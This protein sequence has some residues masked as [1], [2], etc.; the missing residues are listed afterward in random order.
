[1]NDRAEAG[2]AGERLAASFL[3]RAGHRIITRNYRTPRGEIDLITEDGDDLVFVEVRLRRSS[4]YGG[5][6][7][8]VT[9]GK[10]RRLIRAAAR[11]L[12]EGGDADRNCRFDVVS[13]TAEGDRHRIEHHRNAFD[14]EG[15]A[16]GTWSSRRREG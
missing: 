12:A 10:R 5:P 6:A 13:I 8:S 2:R 7:A 16:T 4:G 3:E 15:R 14:G 9:P 11:Y 1:M